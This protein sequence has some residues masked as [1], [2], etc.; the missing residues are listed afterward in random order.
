[1]ILGERD[2]KVQAFPPERTQE[3][4]AERIGLGTPHGGL[5]H[6]QPQVAHALVEFPGED[7]IAVMDE[8]TIA[9]VSWNRITQLLHRPVG[10]GMRGHV[11]MEDSAAW[12]APSPQRHRG[13]KGGCDHHAEIAGDDRLA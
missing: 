7:R 1:M 13:A 3:P 2:Q 10:R 9:V 8:E 11:G 12:R 4:L 5:E 6:P